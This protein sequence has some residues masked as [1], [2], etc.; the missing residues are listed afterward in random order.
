MITNSSSSAE[1]YLITMART[2]VLALGARIDDLYPSSAPFCPCCGEEVPDTYDHQLLGHCRRTKHISNPLRAQLLRT[3]N[4][5]APLWSIQYFHQEA[6]C[7]EKTS[8]LLHAPDQ[9]HLPPARRCQISS[10]LAGWLT[11]IIRNHPL[12][13]RQST[14]THYS[15]L[16]Y[17]QGDFDYLPWTQQDDASLLEAQA[18]NMF[19]LFPGKSRASVSRRLVSLLQEDRPRH[20]EQHSPY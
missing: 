1:F 15:Q 5:M 14:G 4:T 16:R 12:C 17:Q 13:A 6:T 18:H 7:Q 8:L 20:L 11:A 3:L 9:P 2:G 10:L 19:N